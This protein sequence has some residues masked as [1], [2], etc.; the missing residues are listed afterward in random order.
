MSGTEFQCLRCGNCCRPRGYV[1][2]AAGETA[3]IAAFLGMTEAEFLD[4]YARLTRDT[5]RPSL[6][7]K[8]AGSCIFL[9]A[10]NTCRV[11]DVKPRQCRDYPYRW[12]SRLLEENCAA[13]CLAA[14]RGT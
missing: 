5:R 2:L 10:D 8:P 12:R 11:H 3:R 13:A 14:G 9:Q 1:F 6:I 4:R 7:E